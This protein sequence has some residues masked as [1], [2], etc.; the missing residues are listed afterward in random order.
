MVLSSL[1][2]IYTFTASAEEAVCAFGDV[3]VLNPR[4]RFEVEMHLGHLELAGQTQ[5]FKIR[6][7]SIQR[8]FILPKLNTPHTLV[9][10]S[11][12]P[13]IRKGQTYY[14][15]LLCQFASDN[16]EVTIQ[17]DLTPE[18]LAAKKEKANGKLDLMMTGPVYEVFAR[19]LRGLSGAKISKPTSEFNNASGDGTGSSIRCSYKVRLSYYPPCTFKEEGYRG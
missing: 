15:H 9:V 13:P 8:I 11:L 12:D 4:G 5:N 16:E 10:I 14:S 1:A 7:A 6:Y 3:A 17:L 18:Q 2:P 19:A